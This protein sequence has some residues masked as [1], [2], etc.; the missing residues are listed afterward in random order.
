MNAA[1]S[2]EHLGTDAFAAEV[3]LRCLMLDQANVNVEPWL[4]IVPE[5]YLDAAK[6]GVASIFALLRGA[7]ICN[8][9][10]E[11]C[12]SLLSRWA[13]DNIRRAP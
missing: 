1:Q 3:I 8:A 13:Q 4:A 6:L 7:P 5:I 9:T 2:I 11:R 12:A 10:R